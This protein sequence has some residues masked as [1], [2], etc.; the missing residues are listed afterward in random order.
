MYNRL[1]QNMTKRSTDRVSDLYPD[2]DEEETPLPR[3]W[4]SKDKFIHIKLSHNNLRANYKGEGKSHKDASS[5][6]TANPIPPTCGL[7]YY[8][9]TVVS[10]G[11]DGYIGM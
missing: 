5:V 10:K 9:V 11:R 6:R 3:E 1:V 2:V 4:S 8:E 7:Y